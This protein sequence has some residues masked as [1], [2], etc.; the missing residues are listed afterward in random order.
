MKQKYTK[1]MTVTICVNLYLTEVI[2]PV[3]LVCQNNNFLLYAA[4]LCCA[5][6]TV[7]LHLQRGDMSA[8]ES[9]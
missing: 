7:L 1:G 5:V 3:I 4:A 9:R 6:L 8:M 2:A